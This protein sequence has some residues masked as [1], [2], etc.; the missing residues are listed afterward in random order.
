LWCLKLGRT[1]RLIVS[2][3]GCV[4]SSFV[5]DHVA[6]AGWDGRFFWLTNYRSKWK[7]SFSDFA[8]SLPFLATK[9]CHLRRNF[10]D[11]KRQPEVGTEALRAFYGLR[12]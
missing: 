7:G 8:F 3:P 9:R 10:A 5:N 12:N 4:T 6:G 11:K 1:K 2:D